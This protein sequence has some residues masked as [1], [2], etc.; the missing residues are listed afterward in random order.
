MDAS[1]GKAVV[2]MD[3]DLQDPPEVVREMHAKFRE[4]YDVVY[5]KRRTRDGE[6]WFKL[7]TAKV[8]YRVFAAMIPIEVPLDTG[9]FR[10]MSRRV[11]QTL[12]GL[13]ETHRFGTVAIRTMHSKRSRSSSKTFASIRDSTFTDAS[14]S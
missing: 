13:R 8:F 4:G 9:D 7:F 12:R 2:V 1:R 6:T 10:L 5:G 11:V 3:A 14:I